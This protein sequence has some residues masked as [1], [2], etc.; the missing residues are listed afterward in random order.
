MVWCAMNTQRIVFRLFARHSIP[1]CRVLNQQE[2]ISD[3][4]RKVFLHNPDDKETDGVYFGVNLQQQDGRFVFKDFQ[5]GGLA[6]KTGF[7]WVW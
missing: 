4:G 5:E 2:N 6:Y 3:E 1:F 7:R